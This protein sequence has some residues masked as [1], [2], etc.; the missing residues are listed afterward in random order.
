MRWSRFVLHREAFRRLYEEGVDTYKIA[1]RFGASVETVRRGIHA[2]GG[3]TFRRP[4][5]YMVNGKR[6]RHIKST[7]G[8]TFLDMNMLWSQQKGM[9]LWCRAPLP[10]NVLD[11]VVD[12]IGG[13]ETRGDRTKVRG[14]CCK[15]GHCNRIAGMIESGEF[16]ANSLF[17]PLILRIRKV[18][19][20]Y[21][22]G[23]PL[24]S[25]EEKQR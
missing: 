18:I 19:K 21:E 7:Y 5:K 10:K 15:N 2:V 17:R 22:N 12:H 25:T 14:L 8:I 13:L 23:G 6:E 20:M 16:S 9:C 3:E 1:A 24:T 4:R 11:C